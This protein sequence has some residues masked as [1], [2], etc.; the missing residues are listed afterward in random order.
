MTK[1][2]AIFYGYIIVLAAFGIYGISFGIIASFGVFF[3]PMLAE[4]GWTRTLTAGA[5]TMY[6]LLSGV[7]TILMGRLTDRFGPRRVI[8]TF[9][10]FL[11]LGLLLV[12]QVHSP[13]QLY[14]FQGVVVAIGVST[15]I[16]PVTATIARW[17]IKRRGLML[18]IVTAGGAGLGGLVMS[19][20]AGWLI[21]SY[22]WRQAYIIVGLVGLVLVTGLAFLM[23]R[24]PGEAGQFPD[25]IAAPVEF[26]EVESPSR[27]SF[28]L[29]EAIRSRQFWAVWTIF[30]CYGFIRSG[31]FLHLVA[32][33]TDLGFSLAAGAAVLAVTTGVSSVGGVAVGRLADMAGNKLALSGS[34]LIAAVMLLVAIWAKDLSLL[35]L[36]AVVFGLGRGG[37]EVTRFTMASEMFGL[38]AAGAILGA[39][40]FG[41]AVGSAFGPLLAGKIFDV[42]ASYQFAFLLLAA[43]GLIGFGL[44]ACLAPPRKMTT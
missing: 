43:V 1:R 26:K 4:L 19:P 37:I 15:V 40:S 33:V 9:G 39:A 8:M 41:A 14:L 16:A 5:Y 12:S 22:G 35:Y 21:D 25:G 7:L 10:P 28:S 36:F 23:R 6:S 34:F 29:G 38:G 44:A 18:S 27:D 24:T 11:G 17:F 42:T 2:P 32:N 3:K 30:F 13:W 20:V 31:V